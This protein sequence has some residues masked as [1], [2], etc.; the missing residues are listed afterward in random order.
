MTHGAVG[1]FGDVQQRLQIQALGL[2]VVHGA[3]DVEEFGVPDGLL[4]AAEAQLGEEFAYLLAK[5]KSIPFDN[6][7]EEVQGSPD[8]W[9]WELK[10]RTWRW[11]DGMGL[12]LLVEYDG[13]WTAVAYVKSLHE[14]ALFAE[15]ADFGRKYL[16]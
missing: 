3:G 11:R 9:Q 12:N 2:P 4:E 14:A 8:T 16:A 15:G 5:L 1:Q 7:A 13:K 6:Q 10:G